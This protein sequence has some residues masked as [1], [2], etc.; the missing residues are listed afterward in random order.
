MSLLFWDEATENGNFHP[1]CKLCPFWPDEASR[2]AGEAHQPRRWGWSLA[3][4]Q[5]ET[6]AL[7]S[8]P[9][10]ELNPTDNLMNNVAAESSPV[11]SSEK[12]PAWPSLWLDLRTDSAAGDPAK[13]HSVPDRSDCEI[14]NGVVLSCYVWGNLL[15]SHSNSRIPFPFS[16]PFYGD[17]IHGPSCPWPSQP[18]TFP[19]VTW[20]N[21]CYFCFLILF[22]G[23]R[24]GA[25][26][27][28]AQLMDRELR[29]GLGA[30]P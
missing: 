1:A 25:C 3:N 19:V 30:E 28:L 5:P 11:R 22:M 18:M 2:H 21:T 6:K 17:Q 7:H 13:W 23:D 29:A 14:T 10:E 12:T 24:G 27:N 4:S 15:C 26:D 8:K 9:L 20:T 16:D